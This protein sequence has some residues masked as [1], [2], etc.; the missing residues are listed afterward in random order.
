[1]IEPTELVGEHTTIERSVSDRGQGV[2]EPTEL[3]G[4]SCS[5]TAGPTER[6][7][8]IAARQWSHLLPPSE[9]QAPP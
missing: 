7:G 9:W 5:P 2:I 4:E 1:M 3:V 8:W 6:P